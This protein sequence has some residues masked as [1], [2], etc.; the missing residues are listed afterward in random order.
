MSLMANG[1]GAIPVSY[2]N[3]FGIHVA[4]TL[5]HWKKSAYANQTEPKGYLLENAMP[6]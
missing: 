4:K 3:D 1:Y 6:S 5:W 2:L